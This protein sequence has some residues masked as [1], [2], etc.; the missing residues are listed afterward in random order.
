M[1]EPEPETQPEAQPEAQPKPQPESQPEPQPEPETDSTMSGTEPTVAPETVIDTPQTAA[2]STAPQDNDDSIASTP[3]P[4]DGGS[5]TQMDVDPSP[6]DGPD[7]ELG[8][9]VEAG[10]IKDGEPVMDQD[11]A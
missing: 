5:A 11:I 1:S 8:G 3:R 10:E 2:A 4:E 9:E 6:N 7:K